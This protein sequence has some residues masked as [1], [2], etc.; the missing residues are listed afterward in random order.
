MENRDSG[1]G[2][3]KKAAPA[4]NSLPIAGAN[5]ETILALAPASAGF[6]QNFIEKRIQADTRSVMPCAGRGHPLA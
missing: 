2:S 6:G 3:K 4:D 1:D 5:E